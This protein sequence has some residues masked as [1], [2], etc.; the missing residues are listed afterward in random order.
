[1]LLVVLGLAIP[2]G[3]RLSAATTPRAVAPPALT[4]PGL[5]SP[6]PVA[7][8]SPAF[9][10]A[11]V[12]ARYPIN[13]STGG[14]LN[15]TP[16]QL[17]RW[18]G[19]GLADRYNLSANEVYNDN[20]SFSSPRSSLA[21][22]AAWCESARCHAVVQLP[23]EINRSATAAFYVSY[24]ETTL[25]FH[26]DYWELGNEPAAWTH[27]G[28]PWAQWNTTQRLNAT[29]GAYAETVQSY[30]AAMKAVDPGV[31]IIGLAGVGTGAHGETTWIRATVERNGPN[32]SGVAIHVYPAGTGPVNGSASLVGF[33]QS[34][35]GPAS[36]SARVPSDRA[37]VLAACPGCARVALFVTELGS[38][39]TAGAYLGYM[40]GFAQVTYL[41]AEIT[42][43]IALN[44]SSVDLFSFEG[45]Y[46]GSLL[47]PQGSPQPTQALYHDYLSRLGPRAMAITA[48]PTP[49]GLYLAETCVRPGVSVS[50][51]V[52]NTNTTQTLALRLAGL[53][54]P[55]SG[56]AEAWTWNGS[57]AQPV[58]LAVGASAIPA[59]WYLP[60]LSVSL[61]T[62]S[63]G[64][65][66]PQGAVQHLPASAPPLDLGHWDLP[67][68]LSLFA[69]VAPTG[70]TFPCW[71]TLLPTPGGA[72]PPNDLRARL[73]GWLQGRL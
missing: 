23:T 7:Q 72:P 70:L 37:A 49:S 51:L 48:D 3:I 6:A 30:A 44:L 71:A 19:G 18:P 24:A 32:L 55:S 66:S 61:L 21:Q 9:L 12:I 67:F 57:T 27:Y 43:A 47:S 50:L 69:M 56:T 63:G 5:A 54:L 46:E 13:V 58:L 22:F 33:F 35:S 53:G 2:G 59:S 15:S 14:Y 17:V 39:A 31:R 34:L 8:L 42:Q 52:A 28:L 60:P 68:L 29:P 45:A 10:G 73:L 16:V 40:S 20:G 26:P 64:G 62:V 36:L 11:N 1:M 65:L 38:G 4:G 25:G 41:A